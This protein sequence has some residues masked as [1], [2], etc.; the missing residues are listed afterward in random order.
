MQ[1]T[2][3]FEEEVAKKAN[4]E[5]RDYQSLPRGL[6]SFGRRALYQVAK[7]R[8]PLMLRT[9]PSIRLSIITGPPNADG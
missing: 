4:T 2:S 8:L 1:A 9:L 7:E 6:P 3:P 5:S